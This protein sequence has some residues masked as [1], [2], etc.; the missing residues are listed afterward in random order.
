MEEE[1]TKEEFIN[2]SEE[3]KKTPDSVLNYNAVIYDDIDERGS[4]YLDELYRYY[5]YASGINADKMID[6]TVESINDMLRTTIIIDPVKMEELS[7]NITTKLKNMIDL[8]RQN[9][10]TEG[11]I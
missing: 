5:H 1:Q 7:Q 8:K 9:K 6:F 2:D 4:A 10:R 11:L 3:Q